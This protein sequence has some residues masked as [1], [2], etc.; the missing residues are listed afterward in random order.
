MTFLITWIILSFPV[1]I[2][3]GHL[4]S[5]KV[6]VNKTGALEALDREWEEWLGTDSND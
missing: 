3:T 6:L 5:R 2:I 1:G 4:I